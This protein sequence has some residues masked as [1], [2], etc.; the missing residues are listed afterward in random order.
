M[1]IYRTIVGWSLFHCI[2]KHSFYF[3]FSSFVSPQ[4]AFTN[5]YYICHGTYSLC[6]QKNRSKQTTKQKAKHLQIKIFLFFRKR[7]K[8][9]S[10]NNNN[11]RNSERA[12]VLRFYFFPIFVRDFLFSS[13]CTHSTNSSHTTHSYPLE[14]PIQCDVVYALHNHMC[15]MG[16]IHL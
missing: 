16:E 1:S 6:V 7:K 8:R 15:E 10:N 14:R 5:T 2:S 12:T 9:Y 13:F 11:N 3:Y 4:P